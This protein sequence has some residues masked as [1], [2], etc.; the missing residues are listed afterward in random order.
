MLSGKFEAPTVA[1]YKACKF[2]LRYLKKVHSVK[3]LVYRNNKKGHLPRRYYN[4]DWVVV[5]G[6]Q[7][8]NGKDARE[9]T[10]RVC[11]VHRGR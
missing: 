8:K 4:S 11:S 10:E 5:R 2:V 9:K 7:G 3:V 6:Q 1:H